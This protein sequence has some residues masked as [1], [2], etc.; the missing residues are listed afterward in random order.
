MPNKRIRNIVARRGLVA[1][2]AGLAVLA[3]AGGGIAAD[4]SAADVKARFL[5]Q[6]LRYVSWEDSSLAEVK[7]AYVIGVV[8]DDDFAAIVERTTA[9]KRIQGRPIVVERVELSEQAEE[10]DAE[11]AVHLLFLAATRRS[12][13][14]QLAKPL[15]DRPV[16][17]VAEHFDFPKLGGDVGIEMVDGRVSFSISKDKTHGT[18]LSISSKLLRLASALK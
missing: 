14:R 13:L 1:A 4:R 5:Y 6:L 11:A 2:L 12:A 7:G 16:L 17:T 3:F 10:A 15:R 8:G 18:G 9:S